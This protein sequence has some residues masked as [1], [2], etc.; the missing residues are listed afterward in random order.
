MPLEYRSPLFEA[1]GDLSAGVKR[2]TS[3]SRTCYGGDVAGG[4]DLTNTVISIICDIDIAG[5]T[6][7]H[8]TGTVKLGILPGPSL[9]TVSGPISTPSEKHPVPDMTNEKKLSMA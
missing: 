8:T 9:P 4:I 2:I 7:R 1:L 6:H 5:I 3:S